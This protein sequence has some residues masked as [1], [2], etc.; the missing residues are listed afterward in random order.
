MPEYHEINRTRCTGSNEQRHGET[1]SE[2]DGDHL[3]PQGN[4]RCSE[5]LEGGP[6]I[7]SMGF[8]EAGQQKGPWFRVGNTVVWA[9][10]DSTEV[11]MAV[12]IAH[13]K[14]DRTGINTDTRADPLYRETAELVEL[15]REIADADVVQDT[16][17]GSPE[18]ELPN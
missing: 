6:G 12:R 1:A 8:A 13:R 11:G 4:T 7:G 2:A 18:Y 14:G 15:G 10:T 17:F 5:H 3:R 16:C 9:V